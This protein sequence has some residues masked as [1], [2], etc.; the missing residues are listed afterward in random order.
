MLLDEELL[1]PDTAS[2]DNI[3]RIVVKI[4]DVMKSS[5]LSTGLFRDNTGQKRKHK[6]ETKQCAWFTSECE[7][8]KKGLFQGKDSTCALKKCAHC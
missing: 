7:K 4:N 3:N 5:G 1:W 2:L 8:R 6:I